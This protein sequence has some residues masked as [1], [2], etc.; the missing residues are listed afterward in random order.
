MINKNK[1]ELMIVANNNY[2]SMIKIIM[3]MFFLLGI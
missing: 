3:Q 2:D 1:W